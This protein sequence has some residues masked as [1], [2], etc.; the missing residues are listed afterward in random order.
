MRPRYAKGVRQPR[1]RP[2]EPFSDKC[3]IRDKEKMRET[4]LNNITPLRK[5][6]ALLFDFDG[7]ILDTEYPYYASWSEVYDSFGLNLALSD[8]A[9]LIGK[10]A[11]VL[12]RTP[13]EDIEARLGLCLDY[14]AIRVVRRASFDRLMALETA[15]PG[16]ET[17][18]ADAKRHG[19]LLGVASSSPRN[20]VVGYLER[21]GIYDSFDVIRCGDEVERTKPAPDVYLSLLNALGIGADEAMAL[22]DSAHG[23]A[24]A[25]A[26]GL[27]CVVV[28]NRITQHIRAETAD[29]YTESLE[30]VTVKQLAEAFTGPRMARDAT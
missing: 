4:D 14:D 13:Y 28:P 2:R 18:I 19:L 26:A 3:R 11:T 22:E 5:L 16:V 1:H 23:T 27:F 20:W 29:L 24:A 9:A 7:L 8:W 15:L 17:L 25:K 12:A 10:G 30:Y 6:C 21:L